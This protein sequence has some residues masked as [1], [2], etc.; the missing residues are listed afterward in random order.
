MNESP[1]FPLPIFINEEEMKSSASQTPVNYFSDVDSLNP[2]N[3]FDQPP[4]LDGSGPQLLHQYY[5]NTKYFIDHTDSS[6][7][8]AYRQEVLNKVKE[9]LVFQSKLFNTNGEPDGSLPS[10]IFGNLTVS[11]NLIIF[12]D[13]YSFSSSNPGF[14]IT[15]DLND[16]ISHLLSYVANGVLPPNLLEQ[17]RKLNLVWYD[18]GLICEINDT[19]KAYSHPIRVLMRIN[20]IDIT[21][22]DFDVEQEYLLNRYPLLCLDPDIQVSKVS[23]IAL[24]D[25]Q[26]WKPAPLAIR[27]P[28]EFLEHECPSLFIEPVEPQKPRI[29]AESKY[30]E[31]ELRKMLMEKL[32][33]IPSS[34][35]Q[36][37]EMNTNIMASDHTQAAPSDQK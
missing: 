24:S 33:L 13:R 28:A 11:L 12:S 2:P 9:K 7:L 32:G 35:E 5:E 34:S 6:T 1:T 36:P 3:N 30:T 26:R 15:G 21:N 31:E 4:Q 10:N 14:E 17:L 18:G 37:T 25:S 22:S 23:R 19:R 16:D 20:P 27:T 29:R 8:S